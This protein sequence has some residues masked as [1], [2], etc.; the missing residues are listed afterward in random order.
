[1]N[2]QHLYG[3][4]KRFL[5]YEAFYKCLEKVRDFM[6]ENYFTSIGFAKN[7]GCDRAGGNWEIVHTMIDQVFKDFNVLIV[8]YNQN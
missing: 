3:K 7:T 5:N 1:M 8:E 6:K 2:A 4:G